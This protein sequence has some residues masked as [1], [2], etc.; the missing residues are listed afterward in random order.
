MLAGLFKK[1]RTAHRIPQR[2]IKRTSAMLCRQRYLCSAPSE[3]LPLGKPHDS[4]ADAHIAVFWQDG[5]P[6]DD[7]FSVRSTGHHACG[8]RRLSVCCDQKMYRSLIQCIKLL[9]K[10]LF[11]DKYRLTNHPAF[12]TE[13]VQHMFCQIHEIPPHTKQPAANKLP[14]VL[15]FFSRGCCRRQSFPFPKWKEPCR[16]PWRCLPCG[17]RR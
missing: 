4:A 12:I 8:C 7:I 1:G 11:L 6:S 10:A 17:G 16:L 13:R 15:F 3:Y 14:V 9:L 2:L 5:N